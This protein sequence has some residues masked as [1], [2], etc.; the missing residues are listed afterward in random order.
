MFLYSVNVGSL[1]KFS[2]TKSYFLVYL[3]TAKCVPIDL[4]ISR[5][6]VLS[7]LW[8]FLWSQLV[9]KLSKCNMSFWNFCAGWIKT[10]QTGSIQFGLFST[11]FA[12]TKG[13]CVHTNLV[14]MCDPIDIWQHC[15]CD[16]VF[17]SLSWLAALAAQGYVQLGLL[18][19]FCENDD[20][21]PS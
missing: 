12:R 18:F 20:L 7:S 21:S 5:C 4:L 11:K 3:P 10:F 13:D 16:D 2:K 8:L 15:W 1:G 6:V 17:S 14:Q 19:S 9:V